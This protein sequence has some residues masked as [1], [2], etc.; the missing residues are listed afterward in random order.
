MTPSSI[1]GEL[2]DL[3]HSLLKEQQFSKKRRGLLYR[4][5]QICTEYISLSI[6]RNRG[7]P[8]D[9][10]S[11]MV[12]LSFQYPEVDKLTSCFMGEKYEA[13]WHTGMKPLYI[14]SQGTIAPA[15]KYCA[16]DSLPLLAQ[17]IS[18]HI[19]L[20]AL[21]F[22][23]RYDTLDKLELQLEKFP[24]HSNAP[25]NFSLIRQRRGCCSAATYYLQSKMDKLEL[26]MQQPEILSDLERESIR[27]F[28]KKA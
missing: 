8:G 13:H 19:C 6:S 7:L 5:N 2:T 26:L 4:T 24:S 27:C 17:E 11:I 15:Y 16:K 18:N 3:L 10:Y 22:W 23:E 20:Y 28:L 9:V 14:Q 21:P 1:Q 12:N 25:E